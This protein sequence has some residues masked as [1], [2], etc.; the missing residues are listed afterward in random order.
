MH[1]TAK[2]MRLPWPQDVVRNHWPDPDIDPEHASQLR[3][4]GVEMRGVMGP[5]D[6]FDTLM[7]QASDIVLTL[8]CAPAHLEALGRTYMAE[9]ANA[10]LNHGKD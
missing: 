7:S 3:G 4:F 10:A 2:Q 6:A 1:A 8:A 5:L 9:Q